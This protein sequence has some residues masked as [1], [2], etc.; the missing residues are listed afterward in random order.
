MND[1]N[2]VRTISSKYSTSILGDSRVNDLEQSQVLERGCDIFQQSSFMIKKKKPIQRINHEE[3]DI[4]LIRE[5]GWICYYEVRSTPISQRTLEKLSAFKNY[6]GILVLY[7]QF[8]LKS[9]K[10]LL[11][12]EPYDTKLDRKS[13]V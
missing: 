3:L 8:T 5:L 10:S 2:E 4:L 6:H 11:L 13:V 1:L 7:Q 9:K 12:Y